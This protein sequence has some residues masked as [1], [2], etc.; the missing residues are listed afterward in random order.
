MDIATLIGF[1]GGGGIILFAMFSKAGADVWI[2]IPSL[3]ITLGGTL[4]AVAISFPMSRLLNLGKI[5]KKVFVHKAKSPLVL[6]T[7]LVRFAEVARRE[8]ILALENAGKEVTDEFL[9]KGIQLAVDGTDPELIDQ[10]LSTELEFMNERHKDGRSLLESLGKYGPAFGMIGT[11]IGL[12]IM[13]GQLEDVSTLGPSMAIALITT[14]YGALF[15][16]LVALPMADKLALRAEEELLIKRIVIQGVMA[17]QSGD[18]P[19]I[20][21]QKLKIFL[22]PHLRDVKGSS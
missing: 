15:A 3:A 4:G 7:T 13:L 9:L 12:I 20:V 8:G 17:I 18:N 2:S 11:V 10:I 1:V 5:A 14:L 22:P 6:I 19:R 16:N 21:E